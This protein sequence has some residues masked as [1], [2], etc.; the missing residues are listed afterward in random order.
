VSSLIR[1]ERRGKVSLILMSNAPLNVLSAQMRRELLEALAS[2]RDDHEVK[3]IL[4][5]SQGRCFCAGADISEFL[6]PDDQLFSDDCDPRAIATLLE[7]AEVPVLAAIHGSALGGGL[8]L[9]LACHYRVAAPD[10]ELGLPEINL[11]VLPGNGGTQRLPRLV[12]L[13]QAHQMLVSGRPVDAARAYQ[14]GLVDVVIDGDLVT[15]ALEYLERLIANNEPL[16]RTRERQ[17]TGIEGAAS[18]FANARKEA[19]TL[20]AKAHAAAA[21]IGCLESALDRPFEDGLDFERQQFVACNATSE[22]KALQHGFFARRQATKIPQIAA[23]TVSRKVASVGV[24]GGGTMGRGIAMAFMNAG[25]PVSL[26]EADANRGR[27][28]I[29]TIQDQYRHAATTGRMTFD[30]ASSRAPLITVVDAL[31]AI[32]DCDLVIE[33]VFEDL[34]VKKDLCEALGNVCKPGAILATNTSTLNV[35]VLAQASGRPSDFVGMHF[36]SPANVMRLLEIVRGE[37]TAGDVLATAVGIARKLKKDPVVC[38]VCYGFIGNR[39][40][41][42]YLREVEFLL[43]EGATPRQID[44][45][46]EAFGMAMG[47]CRMMDLAGVDVVAKVVIEREKEGHLPSDPRY[48]IVSR[49]MFDA[50]RHGQKTSKGFYAYEGRRALDDED[51]IR[52]I[53]KLAAEHATPARSDISANEIVERCIVPLINEGLKIVDEGIAYRK[54][55]VDVV[56]LGGYGFPAELG[57]PLFYAESIGVDWLRERIDYFRKSSANAYGYWKPAESLAV[58][59][60]V[61][62]ASSPIG[63]N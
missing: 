43:L 16:R 25:F 37:H 60:A 35:D 19:A 28:A 18:L 26:V 53:Q 49:A 4:I 6:L 40:L 59:K 31:E 54:S 32:S 27:L 42:P 34:A 30:E 20:R 52:V 44:S 14:V 15:G 47:P 56:W 36:F 51:A 41:E 63:E 1:T 10:A 46:L 24:V 5:A 39:M 11:G 3:G 9:A 22:A 21:I 57:G 7:E 23:G 58:S 17:I 45:A 8:E 38:G 13:E 61:R 12:G 29:E 2:A 48:R 62:S 50:G 55:D 33:A